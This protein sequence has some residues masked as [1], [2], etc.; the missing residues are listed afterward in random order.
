[1]FKKSHKSRVA[2]HL[3]VFGQAVAG[4]KQVQSDISAEINQ[5]MKASVELTAKVRETE[6]EVGKLSA[7]HTEVGRT[8]EKLSALLPIK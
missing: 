2:K 1:M 3:A 4:L 5:K 6:L 8:I 7:H